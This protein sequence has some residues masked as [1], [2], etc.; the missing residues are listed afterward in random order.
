VPRLTVA[1]SCGRE[2]AM[3]DRC[4]QPKLP[5]S[6]SQGKVSQPVLQETEP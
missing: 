6:S 2:N 1:F 5:A 3:L 4:Q